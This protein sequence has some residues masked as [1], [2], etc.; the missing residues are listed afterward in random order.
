MQYPERISITPIRFYR[1]DMAHKRNAN[2]YLPIWP[3]PINPQVASRCKVVEK[4]RVLW[5][6]RK[7]RGSE[8]DTVIL[9]S[10]REAA[11]ENDMVA[12]LESSRSRRRQRI[13]ERT[14]GEER[15]EQ[16]SWIQ[17]PPLISEVGQG[18]ADAG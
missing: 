8:L 4:A 2:D 14:G 7:V 16:R 13:G 9:R 1:N 12:K 11:D 3:S 17:I 18:G 10:G 15:A 6:N 5:E